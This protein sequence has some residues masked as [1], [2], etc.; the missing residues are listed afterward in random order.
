[1]ALAARFNFV[2][3]STRHHQVFQGQLEMIFVVDVSLDPDMSSCASL[4]IP[5]RK[6][7]GET[8]APALSD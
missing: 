5:S 3:Q 4:G 7:F 2:T 8:G 6:G 1:M